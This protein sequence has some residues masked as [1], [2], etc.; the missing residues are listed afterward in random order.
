[1]T[2][3]LAVSADTHR[4][5]AAVDVGIRGIS[6]SPFAP[7]PIRNLATTCFAATKSQTD[8]MIAE[9]GFAGYYDTVHA[10][11]VQLCTAYIVESFTKLRCN[12]TRLKPGDKLMIIQTLPT[13]QKHVEFCYSLLEN[14]GFI[15]KDEG[16]NDALWRRTKKPLN[17]QD[18]VLS[19]QTVLTDILRTYPD[20]T[21]LNQLVSHAGSHLA[22]IWKGRKDA[23]ST[24]FGS[25]VARDCLE[26]IYGPAHPSKAFHLLMKDFI[27][28]FMDSLLEETNDQK[29]VDLKILELGGGTGGTAKYLAPLLAQYSERLIVSYTFTDLAHG[30]VGQAARKFQQYS[31]FMEYRV[32]D[33]EQ[34]PPEDLLASQ[35]IV[36]AV[37]VVHA[38]SNMVHSLTNLRKFLQPHGLALVMEVQEQLCWADF[39]FGL[40]EGW[41]KFEDGRTHATA[42]ADM[43]K[44]AFEDAG[45]VHV[46]WT[47]GKMK[48]SGLQRIFL[49]IN[50]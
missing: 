5:S 39:V 23:V 17:T 33:I 28:R 15:Y 2:M 25:P 37:N 32:Q 10:A 7:G 30:F 11:Q 46:D 13:L 40:F 9:S 26:D 22:D 45:F 35:H 20:Y 19:S 41:W 29:P 8:H 36:I 47:R 21:S 24:V 42:G 18:A 48:E 43:W 6:G 34:P 4:S 14:A 12:L 38:T 50:S 27:T 31:P 3:D 1:M 44:A 49:A 16:D